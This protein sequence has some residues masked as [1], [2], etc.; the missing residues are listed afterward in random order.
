[1]G[2]SIAASRESERTTSLVHARTR[3]GRDRLGEESA[4]DGFEVV[5]VDDALARE[6]V[7]GAQPDLDWDIA[8][9]G[10]QASHDHPTHR[11]C[12]LFARKHESG[13]PLFVGQLNP[14]NVAALYHGSSSTASRAF[15]SAIFISS[16]VGGMRS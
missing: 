9:L 5:E 3:E 8:N 2:C 14:A 4:G 7:L 1:M 11:G 16:S 6:P 10:G 15:A 12:C 13:P